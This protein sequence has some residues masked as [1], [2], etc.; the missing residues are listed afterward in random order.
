MSGSDRK[1]DGWYPPPDP[2]DGRLDFPATGRN[3]DALWSVLDG[4]LP[5]R[6]P[7]LEVASG[8]GQHVVHFAQQVQGD[9]DRALTFLPSDPDPAHRRSIAAWTRHAS[10]SAIIEPPLNLDTTASDWGADW[11]RRRGALSDAGLSGIVCANMIHIAP[12]SAC[13]GL[14][15]GAGRELAPGGAL[16]LY[17]PFMRGGVHTSESN[18]AFSARLQS[19]DPAWGVRDLD[20]VTQLAKQA[21]LTLE[22]VASMPANNLTVRFVRG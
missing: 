16:V 2:D 14:V 9:P 8:S 15:T 7:V 22:D 20:E 3:R 12:W 5:A 17:G 11:S 1:L 19:R 18:A 6:G 13:E 4:W 10:L 21:G